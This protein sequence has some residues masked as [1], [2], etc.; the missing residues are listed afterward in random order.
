MGMVFY[1]IFQPNSRQLYK[2][3]IH[4]PVNNVINHYEIRAYINHVLKCL[5]I[6]KEDYL[7]LKWF[8]T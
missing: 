8:Q 7:T 4:T 5:N 1:Q 2:Q 3:S 6:K